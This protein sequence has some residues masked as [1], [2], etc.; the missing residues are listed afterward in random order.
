MRIV[1][2]ASGVLALFLSFSV[3]A[4]SFIRIKC[5]DKDVGAQ[6]FING[7]LVGRCPADVLAPPGQVQLTARKAVSNDYEQVYSRQLQVI[8][9]TPQRLELVLGAPQ[10]TAEARKRNEVAEVAAQ[11]RAAEAGNTLAMKKMADYY[12]A[13]TG[14]ARDLSKARFWRERAEVATAQEQLSAAGNGDIEAMQAMANRFETGLGVGKDPAQ[15]YAWRQKAEIATREKQARDEII[16]RETAERQKA[17]LRQQRLDDNSFTF[18]IEKGFKNEDKLP[19]TSVPTSLLYATS[20]DLTSAPTRTTEVVKIHNEAALRP[21]TWG[22]PNSM[23]A[24]ATQQ[25]QARLAQAD[26]PAMQH[27]PQ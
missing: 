15:A 18:F 13:G 23:M 1:V 10:L 26:A 20:F 5:D 3:H 22:K 6:L 19:S 9:G 11:L 2:R 7:K 16:A 21:S 14:V 25:Y 8:D 27:A 17:R 12:E 24:R 4:D